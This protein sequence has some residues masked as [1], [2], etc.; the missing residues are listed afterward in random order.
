[1]PP[2]HHDKQSEWQRQQHGAG[3]A[4]QP[5]KNEPANLLDVRSVFAMC[6]C[7]LSSLCRQHFGSRPGQ[8]VGAGTCD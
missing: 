1:V 4:D 6:F 7:H 8:I 2:G 5:K 3:H